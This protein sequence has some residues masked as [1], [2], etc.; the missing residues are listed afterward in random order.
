MAKQINSFEIII[1]GTKADGPT[2]MFV[3]YGT[4]EST[5]KTLKGRGSKEVQLP[6]LNRLLHQGGGNGELWADSLAEVESDEGIP[7]S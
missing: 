7:Q 3:K 4:E 1:R 6:N 5:D 2:R